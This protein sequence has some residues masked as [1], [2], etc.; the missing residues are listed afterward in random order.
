MYLNTLHFLYVLYFYIFIFASRC[1]HT[2]AY[3]LCTPCINLFFISRIY[4][5]HFEIARKLCHHF[6]LNV[7]NYFLFVNIQVLVIFNLSGLN[8]FMP[9]LICLLCSHFIHLIIPIFKSI[10]LKKH[11][12]LTYCM[13]NY[14]YR[15]I[16]HNCCSLITNST[17]H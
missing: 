12:V 9:F 8:Y 2:L 6:F 14:L 3:F 16:I 17:N 11:I 5:K 15:L 7:I 1:S 13:L 10:R 4:V